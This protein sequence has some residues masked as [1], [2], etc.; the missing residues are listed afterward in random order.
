MAQ[1]GRKPGKPKTGGRKA[2]TPNK[3]TKTVR[4]MISM[5]IESRWDDVLV[6]FDSI[7]KPR[8]KCEVV[9]G[10]LPFII[11]KMAT[12]EYKDKVAT[13]TLAD[14]LDE[15]TGEKTRG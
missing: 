15:I 13:K 12:V 14:E 7:E 8:D 6:A 3:I 1:A 9:I 11:P 4:D 2:G 10:M 5:L